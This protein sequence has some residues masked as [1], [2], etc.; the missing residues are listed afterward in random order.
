MVLDKKVEGNKDNRTEH[1]NG[2]MVVVRQ[3]V[4]DM[5][6]AMQCESDQQVNDERDS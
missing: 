3:N 6:D 2:S 5:C 4:E 1:C